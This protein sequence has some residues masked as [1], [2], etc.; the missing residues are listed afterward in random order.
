MRKKSVVGRRVTCLQSRFASATPRTKSPRAE[1]IAVLVNSTS[2]ATQ[3]IEA[4]ACSAA[5][6]LGLRLD[7]LAASTESEIDAA[8]AAAAQRGAGA[9]LIAGDAYFNS[10]RAQLIAL[11][12]RY[13]PRITIARRPP[14]M[15]A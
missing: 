11:A 3:T 13:N 9:L 5:Q 14:S 10:R 12:A 7:V 2:P 8:F 6:T 15:V 4:E 1:T